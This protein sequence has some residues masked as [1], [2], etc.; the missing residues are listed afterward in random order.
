M[1]LRSHPRRLVRPGISLLE[2]LAALAIFLFSIIVISQIVDSAARTAQRAQRLSRAALLAD[3][4]MSELAAGVRPMSS[5][6]N[7]QVVDG[8]THWTASVSVQPESWSNVD[9]DGQLL[10]GLNV[11]QVTV[12]W[13]GD[14][15]ETTEYTLSRVMMDPRLQ[16]PSSSIPATK[17]NDPRWQASGAGGGSSAGSG[18]SGTGGSGTGGNGGGGNGGGG[19]GG[20]GRGGNG[21]GGNGGGNG[22]GG[23]GGNGGGGNPRGGGG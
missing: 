15:G 17:P 16:L 10:N 9:V 1:R 7:E 14:T 3:S 6:G 20:G 12:T 2:V 4:L 21:G 18:G 23:R 19:N 5:S 8:D 22:G 13:K 11:V